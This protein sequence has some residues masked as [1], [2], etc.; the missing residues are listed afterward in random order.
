VVA[1]EEEEVFRVL[2]LV[3]QQKQYGFE[4]LLATIHIVPEEEVVGRR[5]EAAHLEQA[6]EVRV[7]AVD[8]ADDLDGRGEL[9]ECR[10]GEE[11]VAGGLADGNDLCVLKAERLAHFAGVADVEQPLD[12]VVD[13]EGSVRPRCR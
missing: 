1:S 4:A 2:D 7:L 3:A 12:H 11:D 8:V 9:D 13:V 5:R 6:D 10:L